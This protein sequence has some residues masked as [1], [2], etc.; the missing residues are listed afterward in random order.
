MNTEVLK[1]Y[2]RWALLALLVILAIIIGVIYGNDKQAQKRNTYEAL[3]N[4]GDVSEKEIFGQAG[5]F[6]TGTTAY[7]YEKRLTKGGSNDTGTAAGDTAINSRRLP[8]RADNEGQ[9]ETRSFS[10]PTA[11]DSNG[12]ASDAGNISDNSYDT[13]GIEF[14]T[15][16]YTAGYE[17][18]GKRPGD[19]LYGITYSGK[20][21][22]EN[23]T[24]A[25]DPEVLPIGTVVKIEGFDCTFVVEDTGS[26]VNGQHIDIYMEDLDDAKDYGVQYRKIII[27]KEGGA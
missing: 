9:Q 24:I 27:V 23:H 15:T 1:K 20:T 22:Q 17:S 21:V 18:T 26:A 12:V 13:V 7:R 19:P 11:G 4:S 10:V 3:R 25:A 16:A 2:T 8:E 6:G 5:S 14:K